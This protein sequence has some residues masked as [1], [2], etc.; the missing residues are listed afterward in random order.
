MNLNKHSNASQPPF[1]KKN[2]NQRQINNCYQGKKNRLLLSSVNLK[3]VV[4]ALSK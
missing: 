1:E 2:I 3:V 4:S